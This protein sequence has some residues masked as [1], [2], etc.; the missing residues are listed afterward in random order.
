[1]SLPWTRTTWLTVQ[2]T[3]LLTKRTGNF[4]FYYF[5][6]QSLI[7]VS[8]YVYM[9]LVLFWWLMQW[10]CLCS[11]FLSI[12]LFPSSAHNGNQYPTSNITLQ[13]LQENFEYTLHNIPKYLLTLSDPI[14]SFWPKVSVRQWSESTSNKNLIFR[15]Y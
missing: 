15:F 5:M 1:M 2:V 3:W 9:L 4:S 13:F 14:I 10:Q 6:S 11:C 8:I 12:F 7:T